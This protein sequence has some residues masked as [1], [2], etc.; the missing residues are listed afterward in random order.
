[1]EGEVGPLH[2]L[3]PHP[4]EHLLHAGRRALWLQ[5]PG[6]MSLCLPGAGHQ[7]QHRSPHREEGFLRWH[8]A[9]RPVLGWPPKNSVLELVSPSSRPAITPH[10]TWGLH[11]GAYHLPVLGAGSRGPGMGRA[12]FSR[13]LEPQPLPPSSCGRPSECAHVFIFPSMR[14]AHFCPTLCDPTHCSPPV[15]SVRGIL[16]SRTLKWVAISFS[17]GF[18]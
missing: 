15:S 6:N 13:G 4:R 14:C 18:S 5:S 3:P 10:Q 2:P 7:P 16:H 11:K 17:R 12:G 9:G 1:M 8:W